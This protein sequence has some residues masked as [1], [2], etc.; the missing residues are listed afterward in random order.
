MIE[1]IAGFTLVETCRPILKQYRFPRSKKKRIRNKWAKNE[2]N[3]RFSQ[4]ETIPRGKFLLNE[5]ER[6]IFYHYLDR[7]LLLNKLKE[8]A[9]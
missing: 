8:D 4:I 5:I 1:I 6:K 3:F 7:E 9:P 2:R